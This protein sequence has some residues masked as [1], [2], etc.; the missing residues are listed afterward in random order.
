VA[1][2]ASDGGERLAV[3]RVDR[4]GMVVA[5]NDAALELLGPSIGR[6]CRQVVSGIKGGRRLCRG[7]CAS[8]VAWGEFER[9]DRGVM[10]RGQVARLACSTVGDEAVVAIVHGRGDLPVVEALSPRERE[11][12]GLVGEGL[13]TSRIADRLGIAAATVRTHVENARG[14]LGARS[15]AEAVTRAIATG[16]LL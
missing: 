13:T 2:Q 10:V 1:H 15:R 9:D 4:Q 5:Q 3:L 6:P 12:L 8:R 7:D 16:Q 14:K 11:V